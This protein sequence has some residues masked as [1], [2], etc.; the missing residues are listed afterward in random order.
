[1]PTT[2]LLIRHPESAWNARGIYQGQIDTPLSPLGRVQ[3]ELVAAR[4]GRERIDGVVCSPLRRARTLARAICR[5][6]RLTPRPDGRL[7]EISHGAWEGLSRREVRERFPQMHRAWVE[8]PH[9]VTFPGGESLE[10]VHR[11]CVAPVAA[12]LALAGDGVWAVV[13]HDT[14]ARLVIA[15][16]RDEPVVGFAG[17]SLENAAITTLVGPRLAGSVRRVNEVDHL[18]EHRVD[19]GGQAL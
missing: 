13:T 10:D 8:R 5:Y 6:H 3:A 19:L 9:A 14:V 17:V 12:L 1:M 16:A 11:R 4:L 7:T 2:V 15:A 18:G